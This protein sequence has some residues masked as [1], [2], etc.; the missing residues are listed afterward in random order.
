MGSTVAGPQEP[1]RPPTSPRGPWGAGSLLLLL[2]GVLAGVGG[3]YLATSSVVV[4]LIAGAVAIVVLAL[5][6]SQR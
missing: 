4:T 5:V 3:V 2:K 1:P 6:L